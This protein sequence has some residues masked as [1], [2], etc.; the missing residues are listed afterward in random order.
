MKMREIHVRIDWE[1]GL[2]LYYACWDDGLLDVSACRD[3][4]A[5][6]TESGNIIFKSRG[7]KTGI[8]RWVVVPARRVKEYQIEMGAP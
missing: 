5:R 1:T 6:V 2:P 4:E 7:E 8:W 3:C